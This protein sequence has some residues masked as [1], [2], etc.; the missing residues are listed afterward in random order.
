MQ[1]LFSVFPLELVTF[2]VPI[3][4]AEQEITSCGFSG[5]GDTSNL[6]YR[7]LFTQKLEPPYLL[8]PLL[9]EG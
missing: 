1:C 5:R 9:Q 2:L 6:T 4:G 7:L 8:L 3:K